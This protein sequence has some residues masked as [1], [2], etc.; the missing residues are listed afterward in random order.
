MGGR[1]GQVQGAPRPHAV[2]MDWTR[3]LKEAGLEAPGYHEAAEATA[4]EWEYK[5]R[6]LRAPKGR[7]KGI[8]RKGAWPSLKHGAD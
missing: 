7:G 4:R 5:Q 2:L 6:M 3:I 1:M 8:G